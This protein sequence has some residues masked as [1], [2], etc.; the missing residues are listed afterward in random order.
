M[1]SEGTS[2][3]EVLLL[4]QPAGRLTLT[5]GVLQFQYAPQWLEQPKAMALSQSLPLQAEPFDDPTCRPFFAGLLPEG[6]LRQRIAQRCQ[7]SASNDFG[8][9]AAIGGD[10]AGAVSLGRSTPSSQQAAVEWL[11]QVPLIALLND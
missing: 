10:C 5:A 9:L 6:Q 7:V 1:A 2:E 8:L 4:E 11:E 3:L